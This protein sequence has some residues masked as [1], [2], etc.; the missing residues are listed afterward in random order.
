[1]AL[2]NLWESQHANIIIL[3]IAADIILLSNLIFIRRLGEFRLPRRYPKISVLIPAR[4]E[5]N[6][7]GPCV[8]SLLRQQYPNF[9]V[10]VMDDS[11]TDRTGQ[12][13][14]A[15]EVD[16]KNRG[17]L[18]V[19][20]GTPLPGGWLGKHW[21]CQ[22]LADAA[23]GEILLFSDA[24]T[25]YHPLALTE[26]A[27][28]MEAQSADMLAVIP[29]ERVI[30]PAEKLLVPFF[31]W[32]TLTFLPFSLAYYVPWSWLSF[33]VGQCML[34]RREAYAKIGGHGAVRDHVVDDA[35]L[36][37]RIKQAGLRWRVADGTWR[38]Q[39]RMYRNG[40]EVIEGFSKNTFPTFGY[41]VTIF[42]IGWL[43]MVA[44]YL[45]PAA[46]LFLWVLDQPVSLHSIQMVV[47]AILLGVAG[48]FGY[49]WRFRYPLYLVFFYPITILLFTLVAF[50]S[51]V[52]TLLGL[53]TWK[54]RKLARRRVR[55]I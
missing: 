46:V 13:L 49:Y 2:I 41:N 10:L 8:V 28:A 32:A 21:A 16:E 20:T 54:D 30:S 39:C 4:N 36:S 27:A 35:A 23:D 37:R 47:L 9:E 15:L 50:R 17:C 34:F 7:I 29:S 14:A 43:G 38:V 1:M 25:I 40:R 12:I 52:V 11:S 26:I 51:L 6:N 42:L 45:A 18:R 24:D 53:S 48:W 31:M 33:A 44:P 55:L 5:E 3:L 22:Q 19:L